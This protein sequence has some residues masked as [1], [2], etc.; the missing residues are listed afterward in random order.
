MVLF[1]ST[2]KNARLVGTLVLIITFVAGALAGAAVF[3]VVSAEHAPAAAPP[4]P[5]PREGERMRGGPRRLLLDEQFSKELGLSAEQRAQ[6]KAILDKRDAEAK[7]MWQT[8][9]PRLHQFGEAVHKE[10]QAVLTADQQKQLD[11]AIA[12]RR[13]A[14]KDKNK[15]GCAPDSAREKSK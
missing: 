6:I 11:A 1:G 4:P 7:K 2:G 5:E 14:F 12:Q 10:I 9:E 3:R 15:H 8:F 13:A